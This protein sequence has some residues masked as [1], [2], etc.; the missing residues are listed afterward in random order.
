VTGGLSEVTFGFARN[1]DE[2][3]APVIVTLTSASQPDVVLARASTMLDSTLTADS[4]G[5]PLT[6]TLRCVSLV[7]RQQYTLRI[8]TL[9]N[10]L[11]LS[12]SAIAN[13]TDYDWGLPFRVDGYD[14][15]GGLYSNDDLV[16]QVY[17][18]DDA[19]KL[20]RFVNVLSRAIT[21]PSPPIINTDRSPAC[22]NAIR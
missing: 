20:E 16:L 19:N 1:A 11:V 5:I 12:G 22:P 15:Y 18:A 4:R 14:P 10:G 6:L 8:E 7:Q 3:P 21:S 13:E 9:G 2:T 17:W